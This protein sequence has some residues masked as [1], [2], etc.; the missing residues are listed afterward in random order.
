MG[1]VYKLKPEIMNFILEQK[2]TNPNLSCRGLTGIVEGKFQIKLSKSSINSIIKAAGLSM[3][4][5]RRQ[6]K[7]RRLLT[8]PKEEVRPPEAQAVTIPFEE[9]VE[10]Q[11]EPK[12]EIEYPGT[13]LLKAMDYLIGGSYYFTGAIKKQLNLQ[14][15]DLWAK[16]EGL[17]NIVLSDLY[18]GT[19]IKEITGLWELIG[20][21]SSLNEIFSY[22]NEIQSVKTIALDILRFIPNIFQEVRCLKFSLSDG[23][24]FYLDGQLHT[25]WSTLHI[26]YD[27]TTTIYNIKSYVNMYFYSDFPFTLFA[28]PG[29]DIPTKEF[30]NFILSLEAK[31][32]FITR[33][34]L[35][36]NKFEELETI[37][38]EQS[39]KRFFIFGLWPWQF[40]EFRK[41]KKIGEFKSFYFV[42][43]NKEFYIADIEIELLQPHINQS[44]TIKGYALKTN[45]AE[46]TRVIILSNLVD[47]RTPPQ[48]VLNLYLGHWPNLEEGFQDFSRKIELFTYTA[49]SEPH[50]LTAELN[51]DQVTL[52]V[53]TVLN[54]Y[55]QGLDLYVKRYFF[56]F[57]Y[58]DKDY[59]ALKAQIYGLKTVLQKQNNQVLVTFK[60]TEGFP[61]LK[62]LEYICRR[63]NEREINLP[64][65]LRMWF[66]V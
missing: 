10:L 15:N 9:A 66:L 19:Q 48:E 36:S 31:D 35:Y 44:L 39:R 24:I 12:K 2:K 28:A 22:L 13:I 17:L 30:F 53:K 23:S 1:V 62:E 11:V 50:S 54:K 21:K 57:G 59:V 64:A 4:V 52:E 41:V 5:G 29:Y 65:K 27:F 20:Q 49:G 60:L 26:P 58:E 16:T 34:T 42:P 14:E 33:L 47:E 6:K 3:P 46:K 56:P 25:V 32:K 37:H 43:L 8:P 63:L 51:L 40:V 38:L 45:L 55:I 61:F 7:R 18:K